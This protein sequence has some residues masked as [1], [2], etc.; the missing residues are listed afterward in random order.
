M[1]YGLVFGLGVFVA[2]QREWIAS[3]NSWLVSS[4]CAVLSVVLSAVGLLVSY[5]V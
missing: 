5:R 2:K 4:S 1:V 3:H